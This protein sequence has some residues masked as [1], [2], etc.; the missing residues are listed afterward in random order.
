MTYCVPD[1]WYLVYG[2]KKTLSFFGKT[3]SVYD[4]SFFFLCSDHA[5]RPAAA[6]AASSCVVAA[7]ADMMCQTKTNNGLCAHHQD[8]QVG[9]VPGRPYDDGLECRGHQDREEGHE[10]LAPTTGGLRLLPALRL[11]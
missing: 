1:T 8:E 10:P 4:W 5:R 2:K 6:A 7:V 11:L 3:G 9:H